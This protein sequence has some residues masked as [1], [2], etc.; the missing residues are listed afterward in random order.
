MS[1]VRRPGQLHTL[2][3]YVA[4]P[5]SRGA[6]RVSQLSRVTYIARKLTVGCLTRSTANSGVARCA[7]AVFLF[8]FSSWLS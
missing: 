6:I 5:I 1:P 2:D 3:K 4:M 8:V 7:V